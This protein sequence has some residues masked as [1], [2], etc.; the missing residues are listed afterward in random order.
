MHWARRPSRMPLMF[1]KARRWPGWKCRVVLVVLVSPLSLLG[2]RLVLLD[3]AQADSGPGRR[4]MVRGQDSSADALVLYGATK[5]AQLF[6]IN[7][8]TGAGT[9]IGTLPGGGS[10]EI[11]F[12][13]STGR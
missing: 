7:L 8:N 3:L 5:D 1:R 12:D 4:T 2:S 10:T 9:L 13:N 11:E 6:S